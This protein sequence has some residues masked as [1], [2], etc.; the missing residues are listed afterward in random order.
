MVFNLDPKINVTPYF[1][2][3]DAVWTTMTQTRSSLIFPREPI[4]LAI[5]WLA[6]NMRAGLS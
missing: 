3:S 4:Y 1:Y 6:T 5:R 2:V